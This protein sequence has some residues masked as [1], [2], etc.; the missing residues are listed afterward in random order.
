MIHFLSNRVNILYF[1]FIICFSRIHRT[2]LLMSRGRFM[3]KLVGLNM[4]LLSTP[5][6]RTGQVRDT[7]LLYLEDVGSYYCVASFGGNNKH[8]QWFMN[9]V[10]HP[11]VQLLV[12]QRRFGATAC[13]TSGEERNEAWRSL[14]NYYPPFAKYQERTDRIIPVVRLDPD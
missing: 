3:N 13:V 9:L 7:P 10:A 8:P 6:R 12:R 1:K 14:I 11:R 4:L 5:G 2:I